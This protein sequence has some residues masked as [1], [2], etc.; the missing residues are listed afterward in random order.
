MFDL[1]RSCLLPIVGLALASTLGCGSSFNSESSPKTASSVPEP[2]IRH[3]KAGAIPSLQAR[4]TKLVFFGSGPSDIAPLKNPIYKSRFEHSATK[5][6][7]PEIHLT[8]PP[9]DK[10]IYFTLTVHVRENGKT[11]RMV[12]YEGRIEPSWTS[13]HHSVGIGIMGPG[14]WQIG[15]YEADVHINGEKVATGFF[16]VF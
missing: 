10:R 7:H 15:K 4:V 14:N 5:T 2:K 9:P 1:H 11:L 16:E 8:Y 13:S 3:D 12:D 6:V